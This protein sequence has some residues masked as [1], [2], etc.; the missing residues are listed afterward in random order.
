MLLDE[1]GAYLQTHGIGTL[2][3]DL[4]T[5]IMPDAPDAAVALIEYGGVE[6]MHA[7]GGGTAKIERPRLQVLA[8]ATTYS[9]AR[10]KI[11]AAYKV[12]DALAGETLSGVRYLAVEALQSP[13]FLRRDENNRVELIF[14]VQVHKELSP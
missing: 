13:F 1:V 5:G 10:T 14:N 2:G 11:E 8:R 4:F 6:P 7:L 3:T 9:A 12:L